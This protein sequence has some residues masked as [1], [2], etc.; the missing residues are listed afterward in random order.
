MKSRK[1]DLAIAFLQSQ[2]SS[3]ASVLEQQSIEHVAVF[4]S[5]ISYAH[6]AIAIGNMLPQYVAKICQHIEPTV[7]AAFMS[8]VDASSVAAIMRHLDPEKGH[9]IL[10]LL[11]EKTKLLCMFLLYY[12]EDAVGA[13]MIPNPPVVPCECTIKEARKRFST[14]NTIDIGVIHIVDRDRNL[15]GVLGISTLFSAAPSTQISTVMDKDFETISGRA[16]VESAIE[17]SAWSR[18]ETVAVTN[19]SQKLVGVIRHVDLRRGLKAASIDASAPIVSDPLSGLIE[20]YGKSLLALLNTFG[21]T[22]SSRSNR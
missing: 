9:S 22:V 6:A 2:P 11:P 18:C 19:R 5:E 21:E 4:L 20:V 7:A 15:R 3:A 13:W 14:E 16:S 17:H 12:Q 1:I 8:E 10:E